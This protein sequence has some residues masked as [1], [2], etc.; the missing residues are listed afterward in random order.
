ME[1]KKWLPW[2]HPL[3]SPYRQYLHSLGWPLK[4]SSISNSLVVICQTKPVIA[5]LVPK[6]VAMA[7]SLRPSISAMS[8]SDSL[9][10]KTYSLESNRESLAAI[11]PM[12]Y[13]FKVYLPEGN[14]RSQGWLGDPLHVWYGRPH[15]ATDWPYCFRFP[16][17]FQ[18]GE[19]RGS[20][21]ILGPQIGEN[22][23]FCP[24]IY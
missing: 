19:W 8:S 10:R 17:F 2:Q 13:R 15:L 23:V 16:D 7:T 21:S 11:Q 9:T 22:W 24:Q 14:N 4:H 18:I 6:L 5:I 3:V 12:L 1:A 20:V